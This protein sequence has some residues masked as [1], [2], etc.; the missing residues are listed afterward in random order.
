MIRW[1][2]A[3]LAAVAFACL[4]QM[5]LADGGNPQYRF[6]TACDGTYG[7]LTAS[8]PSTLTY[9]QHGQACGAGGG[10]GGGGGAITAA[11]GSYA[12]GA[13]SVG[14]GSD[15]WDVAQGATA[16]TACGTDAG[17]GCT[18]LQRLAR[19]A[20]NLTTLNTTAASPANL[21]AAATGGAAKTGFIVSNNTTGILIKNAP[22]TL[23]S[24]QFS[25]IG[26]APVWVKLYDTASVPTCGSGTP[27]KRLIIPAASTAANGAGSNIT[28]GPFGT[29]F[30]TGIAYCVTGGIADADTTTPT[31]SSY[32]VNFDWN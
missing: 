10:G 21:A 6:V 15:G 18:M 8:G 4:P 5:A 27:V 26:S 7:P 13:F 25:G 32:T 17:T 9:D 28:F 30:T 16:N 3:A 2:Y 24:A 29:A 31:I 11:A 22:G 1:L 14:S 19:I 12:I 20:V 23:Y